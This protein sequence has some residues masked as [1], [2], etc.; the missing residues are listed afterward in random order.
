MESKETPGREVPGAPRAIGRSLIFVGQSVR[1]L[2]S[3]F[4]SLFILG[5]LAKLGT[6]SSL[7]DSWLP[8][9]VGIPLCVLWGYSMYRILWRPK[10]NKL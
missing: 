6:M 5:T 1:V 7:S 8:L 9:L 2:W 4:L 3:I 10:A